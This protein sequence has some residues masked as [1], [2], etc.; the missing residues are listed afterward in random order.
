MKKHN[1][2]SNEFGGEDRFDDWNDYRDYGE[3]EPSSS[4][5]EGMESVDGSYKYV[6]NPNN[7]AR[8]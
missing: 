4:S 6:R 2:K 8:I 1:N 5:S 3:Y 7:T